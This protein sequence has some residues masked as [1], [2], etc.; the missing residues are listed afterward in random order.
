MLRGIHI[1]IY[2][3]LPRPRVLSR[4]VCILFVEAASSRTVITVILR[5]L[6]ACTE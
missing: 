6:K 3:Y 4:F 2:V 5:F 1:R